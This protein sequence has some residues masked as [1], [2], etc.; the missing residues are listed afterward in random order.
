MATGQSTSNRRARRKR[1][2]PAGVKGH[3][4]AL[5]HQ[6]SGPRS[7]VGAT[8]ALDGLSQILVRERSHLFDVQSVLACLHFALLHARARRTGTEVDCAGAARIAWGLLR[9][10]VDRLDAICASSA[11][12]ES[13]QLEISGHKGR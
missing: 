11:A 2:T 8:M 3:E 5:C 12:A 10:C 9:D 7:G 1:A 13:K 4:P 6:A